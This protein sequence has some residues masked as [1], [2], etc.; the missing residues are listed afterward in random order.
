VLDIFCSLIGFSFSQDMEASLLIFSFLKKYLFLHIFF[1]SIANALDFVYGFCFNKVSCKY[2][3][4]GP[5]MLHGSPCIYV[6]NISCV[7]CSFQ[8]AVIDGMNLLAFIAV[9][10]V[11][12]SFY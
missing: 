12:E 10:F 7:D 1:P 11:L 2:W 9:F 3:K 4:Y 6:P 8:R 5:S